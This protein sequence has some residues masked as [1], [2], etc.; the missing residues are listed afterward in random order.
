MSHIEREEWVKYSIV[1]VVLIVCLWVGWSDYEFVKPQVS[2]E[3]IRE[4]IRYSV[5]LVFQVAVQYVIPILIVGYFIR[6]IAS[7]TR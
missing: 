6:E 2:Q 1:F 5:R 4:S 3:E 7:K